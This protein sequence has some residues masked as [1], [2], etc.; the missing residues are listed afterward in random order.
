M[1]AVLASVALVVGGLTFANA[2]S[3]PNDA[4]LKGSKEPVVQVQSIESSD[5][6]S[7]STAR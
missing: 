3:T 4:A 5:V 2:V 1:L 6:R 7:E